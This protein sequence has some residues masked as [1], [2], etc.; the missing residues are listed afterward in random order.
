MKIF[1]VEYCI[2]L[3]NWSGKEQYLP[4]FPSN[5]MSLVNE[6]IIEDGLNQHLS[7]ENELCQ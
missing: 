1:C 4:M 2:I 5:L 7:N 3:L 6:Y